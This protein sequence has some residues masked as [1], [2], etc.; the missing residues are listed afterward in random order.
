MSGDVLQLVLRDYVSDAA[1]QFDEE[2]TPRV[3]LNI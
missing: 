3:T 2:H 1:V